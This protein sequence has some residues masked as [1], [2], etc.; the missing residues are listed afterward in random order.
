MVL[1]LASRRCAG[2]RQSGLRRK[3]SRAGRQLHN[4]GPFN[5]SLLDSPAAPPPSSLTVVGQRMALIAALQASAFIRSRKSPSPPIA[6]GHDCPAAQGLAD[7]GSLRP[8]AE[9]HSGHMAVTQASV[10]APGFLVSRAGGAPGQRPAPG[11]ESGRG[12]WREAVESGA[13]KRVDCNC[14]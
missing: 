6:S 7:Y 9:G 4:G 1:R 5:S 12:W 14:S 2:A 10:P 13:A 3:L 11:F 8:R